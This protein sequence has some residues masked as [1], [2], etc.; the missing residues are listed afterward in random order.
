MDMRNFG[1]D[2]KKLTTSI[3][4]HD[5]ADIDRLKTEKR[6]KNFDRWTTIYRQFNLGSIGRDSMALMLMQ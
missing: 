4:R 6:E 1:T 5:A 2:I 3:K